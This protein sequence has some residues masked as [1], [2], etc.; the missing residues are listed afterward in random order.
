M[1]ADNRRAA[2]PYGPR[3]VWL[4][5]V[6]VLSK[7]AR[8]FYRLAEGGRWLGPLLIA[9]VFGLT[10]SS[11]DSLKTVIIAAL[12]GGWDAAWRLKA[13]V[14][15]LILFPLYYAGLAALFALAGT[16]ICGRATGM[17]YR[18]AF[19]RC[20]SVLGWVNLPLLVAAGICLVPFLAGGKATLLGFVRTLPPGVTPGYTFTLPEPLA[21]AILVWLAILFLV[22]V[23]QALAA[24]TAQAL[25]VIA[26]VGLIFGGLVQ[27]PLS[28][29][30]FASV[31]DDGGALGLGR[32]R[33]GV[34]L[35]AYRFTASRLPARGDLIAFDS[36]GTVAA[37]LGRVVG[38]PGDSVAVEDGNVL[39]DGLPL[40]E[41]YLGG[42]DPARAHPP[43]LDIAEM[44]V[45]DGSLYVLPDD[46]SVTADLPDEAGPLI[47]ADS[48]RGKIVS[49][50]VYSGGQEGVGY[51][52]LVRALV[53]VLAAGLAGLAICFALG[54][55][56]RRIFPPR[57]PMCRAVLGRSTIRV[58][59]GEERDQI[60]LPP[61]DLVRWSCR[62]CGH[63][64]RR[65]KPD[66]GPTFF[67]RGRKTQW[68]FGW[69]NSSQTARD[70]VRAV[71]EWDAI[72]AE[73]A[74]KYETK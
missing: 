39:L 32:V 60:V 51:M 12:G 56:G 74:E 11:A 55:L 69:S 10:S 24:G 67:E 37:F 49:L 64:K 8:G 7:P 30:V 28:R 52:L 29:W 41:P 4:D 38:L 22:A 50:Q 18:Q 34:S 44:T 31:A 61:V 62:Q 17:G 65:L 70:N 14:V 47:K 57:C 42:L 66:T 23:R 15:F 2:M 54:A 3:E 36:A 68:P 27:T 20:W 21:L 48:V 9:A 33:A 58:Y 13:I 53:Q 59:A 63:E 26:I 40:P 35:L 45:P 72:Y 46:R 71:A 1:D 16:V 6:Q 5:I 25:A 43:E 19:R 73:L